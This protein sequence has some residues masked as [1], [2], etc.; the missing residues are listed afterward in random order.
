MAAITGTHAVANITRTSVKIEA[1]AVETT[2]V[3]IFCQLN[4]DSIV[5]IIYTVIFP[6]G[7][8]CRYLGAFYRCA[9]ITTV[10]QESV[11][12]IPLDHF[13]VWSHEIAGRR[14]SGVF[15]KKCPAP[16]L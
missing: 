1:S 6:V 14:F 7:Y 10:E 5:Y 12:I 15:I 2:A 9:V 11:D 3:D 4:R 13:F 8:I 16:A